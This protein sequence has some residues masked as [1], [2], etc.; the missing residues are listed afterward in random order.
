MVG[1][2]NRAHLEGCHLADD[3]TI[4]G[5]ILLLKKTLQRGFLKRKFLL[6]L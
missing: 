1:Q 2:K 4:S 6:F 3:H 5:L